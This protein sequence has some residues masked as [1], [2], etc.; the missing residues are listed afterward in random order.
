MKTKI[1]EK[2]FCSKTISIP[3]EE[4]IIGSKVKMITH[5]KAHK[6]LL[7]EILSRKIII[8]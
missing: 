2:L 6:E 7:K 4:Q 8:L 1:K 5:S 3:I